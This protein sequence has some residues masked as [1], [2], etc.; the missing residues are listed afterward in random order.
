MRRKGESK[1]LSPREIRGNFPLARAARMS[2][3]SGAMAS[4]RHFRCTQEGGGGRSIKLE[5][6]VT[7]RQQ[8]DTVHKHLLLHA[9][10]YCC[11]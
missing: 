11:R 5:K 2:L 4:I 9:T 8:A 7:I 6:I 1:S 10:V 3:L